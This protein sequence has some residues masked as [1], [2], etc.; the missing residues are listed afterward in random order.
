MY[1]DHLVTEN[2]RLG[3]NISQ[4]HVLVISLTIYFLG[5]VG[6]TE[7]ALICRMMS[8]AVGASGV[9]HYRDSCV[10]VPLKHQA[11]NQFVGHSHYLFSQ[12]QRKYKSLLPMNLD[13]A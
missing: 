2:V 10:L 4:C 1:Q 5:S 11:T 12:A 6:S 13:G 3:H 7:L 8:V 9:L